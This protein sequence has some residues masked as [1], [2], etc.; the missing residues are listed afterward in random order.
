MLQISRTESAL[1]DAET[2]QRGFLYTADPRYLEPY[3]AALRELEDHR[4]KLKQ[5]TTGDR[6]QQERVL[7]LDSLIDTKLEELSRTIELLQQSKADE[8]KALV[9]TNL[10]RQTMDQI[11]SV[12]SEMWQREVEVDGERTTDYLASARRTSW[13]IYLATL[14]AVLGI[15]GVAYL[16]NSESRLKDR[17]GLEIRQREEWFRV[18]LNS[19][20]DGVVATDPEGNV[21]FMNEIAESLTGV[22]L[23]TIK[24]QPIQGVFPIFNENTN[25]PVENPVSKVIEQGKIVG[26]ANHTVLVRPDGTRIPIEDS[27][28]PIRNDR[29]QIVGVVLVFRDATQ[30]RKGQQMLRR[31]EKLAAAGR[32][33]ATMAHEINNPLEAVANLIFIVKDSPEISDRLRQHLEVAEQQLARVSHITRQTLGFYRESMTRS[34]VQL[35]AVINSVLSLYD[36]KL[37]SKN[38]AVECDLDGVPSVPG[39]AGEL[40]QMLANLISNAADALENN[41]K[42]SI[43]VERLDDFDTHGVVIRVADN[44]PGIPAENAERIF[45][46]FFTTKVDVGTGL[47]LWVAKEIAERHGG[48]LRL[49]KP[50]QGTGAVFTVFLPLNTGKEA[51]SA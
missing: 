29:D 30:E 37:Q 36:N 33:A 10:G 9:L 2:G 13:S 23:W 32:L 31:A 51:A 45:E 24:G 47:G 39:L 50:V 27:A 16:V 5:L 28:A 38:I 48:Y 1:K 14:A 8:A 44:G 19:I 4:Q 7:V 20:G 21:T 41:G 42:L 15:L 11:R 43:K 40:R 6:Y 35:Q 22:K 46:P 18:T 3:S 17:H 49:G 12:L 26:L 25:E 34:D